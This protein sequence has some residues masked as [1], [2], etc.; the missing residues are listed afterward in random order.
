MKIIFDPLGQ[1]LFTG[2]FI[3]WV[4]LFMGAIKSP[5]LAFLKAALT[6]RMVIINPNKNRMLSFEVGKSTGSLTYV[7]PK[8]FFLIDPRDVYIAKVSKIPAAIVY[9]NFGISINTK[10]AAAKE[11]LKE[12]GIHNYT[13][14]MA[15]L[16]LLEDKSKAEGKK[17]TVKMNVLGE[18][19][20]LSSIINYFNR[21]ERSDIIESEIQR[22][23]AVQLMQKV[24]E[25]KT[26]IKWVMVA[27]VFIIL[28][29]IGYRMIIQSG[30]IAATSSQIEAVVQRVVR[31]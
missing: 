22:R 14:L 30:G 29:A 15:Y 20:D 25:G 8:G 27:G 16:K 4:L 31:Q 23:T 26:I 17:F 10:M 18:S 5:M 7:N 11:K 9:S 2:G 28:A 12:L 1:I 19:I 24:G 21:N 13:Q 3:S 6:K